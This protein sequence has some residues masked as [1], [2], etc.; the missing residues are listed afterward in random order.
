MSDDAPI[1][2]FSFRAI[3][4]IMTPGHAGT[5]TMQVTFEGTATGYGLTLG[6]LTV[7]CSGPDCGQWTWCGANY[8]DAGEII[9]ATGKG[10]FKDLGTTRRWHTRGLVN[11]SNGHSALVEGDFDLNARTWVGRL[12]PAP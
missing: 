3:T 2:E 8:L 12:L 7:T 1:G 5:V 6:T 11:A 4:F 10:G 9:T